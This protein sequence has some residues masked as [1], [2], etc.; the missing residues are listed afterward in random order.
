MRRREMGL[1]R[2]SRTPI[3]AVLSPYSVAAQGPPTIARWRA[4]R[5]VQ[6][7]GGVERVVIV[8][9]KDGQKIMESVAHSSVSSKLTIEFLEDS[10]DRQ[11]QFHAK[12]ILRARL[13]PGW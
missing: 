3:S 12:S 9:G 13:V 5:A 11:R 1:S 8:V 2:H 7:R 6:M 4:T 10:T